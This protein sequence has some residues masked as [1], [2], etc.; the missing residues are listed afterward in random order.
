MLSP[1]YPRDRILEALAQYS[2]IPVV[3]DRSADIGKILELNVE[4]TMYTSTSSAHYYIT[5]FCAEAKL[6]NWTSTGLLFNTRFKLRLNSASTIFPWP[7]WRILQVKWY[8]QI[9]HIFSPLSTSCLLFALSCSC[10][11]QMIVL[12]A[13][14]DS[15]VDNWIWWWV[16]CHVM[17]NWW[18]GWRRR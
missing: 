12:S 5:S 17:G 11:K 3:A 4:A 15:R 7:C 10:D 9:L 14:L 1:S 6:N 13:V 8:E 18:V 16:R 2:I